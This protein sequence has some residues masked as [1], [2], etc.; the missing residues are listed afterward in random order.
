MKVK[1]H[2]P[3]RIE[4]KDGET[5]TV[6]I[7]ENGTKRLVAYNLDGTG[8]VF[9]AGNLTFT[10]NKATHNQT[11]LVLICTFSSNT[12]GSYE[13]T[14]TGSNGGDT[15]DFTHQQLPSEPEVTLVYRFDI[16]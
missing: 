16:V 7:K 1:N 10:L 5:I 2:N 14:I 4:G 6:A 9:P 11:V 3:F 12:G 8:A 15:S 13:V